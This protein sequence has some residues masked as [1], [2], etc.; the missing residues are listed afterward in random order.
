MY[1]RQ[2]QELEAAQALAQKLEGIT[3][4]VTAKGGSAGR[5]FGSVTA[6]EVAELA[7]A[8]VSYTHLYDVLDGEQVVYVS[9]QDPELPLE[10][11]YW[12]SLSY[13]IPLL[14]ETWQDGEKVYEAKTTYLS[15]DLGEDADVAS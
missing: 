13:A 7:S 11:R 8:P 6:K 2:Q 9:Y 15:D 1:K 5:L 4:K 12:I 14:A 10:E 3:V